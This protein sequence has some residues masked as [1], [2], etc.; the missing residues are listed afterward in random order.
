[1]IYFRVKVLQYVPQ[2]NDVRLVLK[3]LKR[4]LE[5]VKRWR[6][7]ILYSAYEWLLTLRSQYN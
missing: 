4:V 1:M 5:R 3:D 7:A 2:R 6:T